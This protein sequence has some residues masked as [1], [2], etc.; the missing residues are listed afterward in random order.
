MTLQAIARRYAAA[1]FDVVKKNNTIDA[2]Q[3]G[4]T[5][6][7]ALVAGSPELE[8]VFASPGV[9]AAKKLSVAQTLVAQLG[10]PQEIQRLINVLGERDR[11]GLI[12]DVAS[13]FDARVRQERHVLRADVT[14]AVPLSPEK[15]A[16]LA[17]SLG[18]ALG[19]TITIDARVD[20]SIVGG[21]VAKV[22]SWVF[23]G[24]VT[25]QLERM[26]TELIKEN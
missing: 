26:K 19:G 8:S 24:S 5:S 25:R 3:S 2:A 12:G 22:G 4:L 7:A 13:A 6:V 10:V 15:S 14:T 18:K 23:D 17:A 9:P 1:L 20:P 21:V 16:A 11:L